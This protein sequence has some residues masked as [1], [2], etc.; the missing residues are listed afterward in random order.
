MVDVLKIG[1]II[2]GIIV[3]IRFKVALSLTLFAS[4]LVLGLLFQLSAGDMI[5]AVLAAAL[6]VDNLKLVLAL[7][8]V[9]LFSALL[10]GVHGQDIY[11]SIVV[12]TDRR[13][14]DKQINDTIKQFAQ[15][16]RRGRACR[17]FGR[18]ARLYRDRQKDH[19]HHA[20]KVPL[21]AGRDPPAST[22]TGA[23]PSSSTRRIPVRAGAQPPR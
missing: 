14:L 21:R 10:R 11:D 16:S 9:L 1:L 12:V 6:S 3:L 5:D 23:L 13:V 20:A 15:V 22:A 2:A 4:A 17:A 19:H 8:C 7:Q 18:P